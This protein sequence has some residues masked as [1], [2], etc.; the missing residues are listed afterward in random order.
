MP[1]TQKGWIKGILKVGQWSQEAAKLYGYDDVYHIATGKLGGEDVAVAIAG[2]ERYYEGAQVLSGKGEHIL[3]LKKKYWSGEYAL[4]VISCLLDL[5]PRGDSILAVVSSRHLFKEVS[6]ISK[7]GKV[8]KKLK[9]KMDL[10]PKERYTQGGIQDK[11]RG[12]LVA[13]NLDGTDAVVFGAPET[14]SVAAV[15]LDGSQLWKYET[16][17]KGLFGKG[18]LNAGINDVAIGSVNGHSIVVI[19]TFDHAVHL[20]AGNGT[21]IDT[22]R[23]PSNITNVAY[24]KIKGKDAVAVGLYNGQVFTYATQ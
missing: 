4:G 1:V 10:C 17:S 7:E 23:Y 18:A 3:S 20:V 24:G 16:T 13:G 15:S 22:W 8:V 21:Q 6:V 19:G 5:S 11:N 14:R 2:W 9:A 12:K